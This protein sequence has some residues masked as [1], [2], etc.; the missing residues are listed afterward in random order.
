MQMSAAIVIA[1]SA[2][3]RAVSCAVPRQRP[4]RRHRKRSARSHRHDAIVRLDQVAGAGEQERRLAVG[5]D[6]HRLEPP[7]EAIGAPVARELDRCALEI[8]AILFEL[9]LEAREQR[10]GV[11]GGSGEAGEDR[12]VVE[13]ANLAGAVFQTRCCRASPARP[14]RAPSGPGAAR[15]GW[16]SRESLVPSMP[17]GS[18]RKSGPPRGVPYAD[19]SCG[20]TGR[21]GYRRFLNVFALLPWQHCC[22]ATAVEE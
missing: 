5:D 11:G 20:R 3:W 2:I 15:R 10:E 7:Q 22:S 12:L 16:W 19:D 17:Q 14:R 21:N 18:L 1:S 6:Q 8:A 13:P 4:R 9:R